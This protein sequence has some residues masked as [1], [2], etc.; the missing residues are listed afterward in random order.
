VE[1]VQLEVDSLAT[2]T[3]QKKFRAGNCTRSIRDASGAS[4]VTNPGG[5][6]S[7]TVAVPAA[8][9]LSWTGNRFV[10]PNLAGGSATATTLGLSTTAWIG[11]DAA[12]KPERNSIG[13]LISRF[14]I[15]RASL[16]TTGT[17][18]KAN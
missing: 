8:S 10:L 15:K 9:A 17:A 13:D 12:S 3:E 16:L 5:V 7:L 14:G 11:I 4:G 18:L 2:G 1:I 6:S